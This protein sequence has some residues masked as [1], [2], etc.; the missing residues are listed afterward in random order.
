M[1][2][3][4]LLNALVFVL[5]VN[6]SPFTSR[7]PLAVLSMSRQLNASGMPNVLKNDKARAHRKTS[8]LEGRSSVV[9][10]PAFNVAAS[11]YVVPVDIGSPPTEY[12]LLVDTGSSNT[13]VGAGNPYVETQT[14]KK[15][16]DSVSGKYGTG[17]SGFS[18]T[19]FIDTVTLG[20]LVI[21]GQSIGVASTSSG[22]NGIDGVLGLGPVDLTIGSLSPDTTQS[23]PTVTDNAFAEKLIPADEIGI[24]FE[25]ALGDNVARNGEI[26]WG[27][28]DTSKFTGSIHFSPITTV[29]PAKNYWG[30][31]QSITYGSETILALTAGIVDTG[32]TFI[33]IASDAYQRYQAATGAVVDPDTGFLKITPAQYKALKTLDFNING[34]TFQLTPNAQILP[35]AL[36]SALG[37]S[38]NSIFLI[39]ANLGSPSGSGFD[40]VNG[41]SFLERFYSVYDTANKRVGLATTPFT[42]ATSN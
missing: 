30:I 12:I 38:A 24:S 29:A 10:E 33:L 28:V 8:G 19:E 6:G 41:L 17:G 34:Q 32:S 39:V 23:I 20:S 42:T 15:T 9:D 25:P 2:F 7:D 36:N 1:F 35:R 5:A 3:E 21:T 22:F 18:G 37:A 4:A 13:W 26:A 31:D 40:F 16:A 14:S 27:G 11:M